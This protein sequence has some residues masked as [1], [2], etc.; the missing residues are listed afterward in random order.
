MTAIP[1]VSTCTATDCCYN[2]D[3]ACH[4]AAIMVG[5]SHPSC[6]TYI[7]RPGGGCGA[8]DLIGEIGACKV[9]QCAFNQRLMCSAPAI[10]VGIHDDHADCRTYRP[11]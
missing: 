1:K 11:R 10:E 4:A 7:R 8:P 3:M 6:D 2:Q 5:D 9:E